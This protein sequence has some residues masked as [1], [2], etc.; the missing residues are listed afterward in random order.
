MLRWP[1]HETS[2]T[3][4]SSADI[5]RILPPKVGFITIYRYLPAVE[6]IDFLKNSLQGLQNRMV[7]NNQRLEFSTHSTSMW[8]RECNLNAYFVCL[9]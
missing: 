7:L 9:L 8:Y 6:S 3:P 5:S 1:K 4:K 2:L